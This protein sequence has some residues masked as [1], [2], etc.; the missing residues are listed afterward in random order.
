MA[1]VRKYICS[2]CGKEAETT[3]LILIDAIDRGLPIRCNECAYK[4]IPRYEDI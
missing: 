3:N 1:E 2:E 4:E